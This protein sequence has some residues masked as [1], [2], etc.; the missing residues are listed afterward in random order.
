MRCLP[1][2]ARFHF[3]DQ[4]RVVMTVIH[5]ALIGSLALQTDLQRRDSLGRYEPFS[6]FVGLAAL[7]IQPICNIAGDA[8][9]DT[10]QEAPKT[11]KEDAGVAHPIAA[12]A[13]GSRVAMVAELARL[14]QALAVGSDYDADRM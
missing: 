6:G 13:A 12:A 1:T 14:M 10:E 8:D 5:F 3:P 9:T 2:L 4:L 11:M 7:P